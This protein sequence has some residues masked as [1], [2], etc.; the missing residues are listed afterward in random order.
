MSDDEDNDEVYV[1]KRIK[2][3]HNPI[4]RKRITNRMRRQAGT[5]VCWI[6]REK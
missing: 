6:F 4:S 3:L 2:R 5:R 1:P